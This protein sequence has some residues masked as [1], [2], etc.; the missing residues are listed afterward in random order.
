MIIWE[1]AVIAAF[2]ASIVFLPL[3][4][5]LVV[6]LLYAGYQATVTTR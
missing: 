4:A 2:I 6:A 5:P 3:W 1:F